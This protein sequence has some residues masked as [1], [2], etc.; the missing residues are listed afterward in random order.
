MHIKYILQPHNGIDTNF[1]SVTF[2]GVVFGSIYTTKDI[3]L[4][5]HRHERHQTCVLQSIL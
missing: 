5:V 1:N 4:N 2:M 3:Q